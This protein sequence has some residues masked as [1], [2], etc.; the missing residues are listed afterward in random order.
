MKMGYGG[1]RKQV[2]ASIRSFADVESMGS[3]PEDDLRCLAR[4]ANR[5]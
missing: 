4:T 3:S 1:P 5:Y 2:P